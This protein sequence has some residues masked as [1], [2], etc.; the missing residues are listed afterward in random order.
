MLHLQAVHVFACVCSSCSP[1][2]G[3]P[4]TAGQAE[5]QE[6]QMHT[7]A[8]LLALLLVP[9][10]LLKGRQVDVG[11]LLSCAHHLKVRKWPSLCACVPDSMA[12]KAGGDQTSMAAVSP[13]TR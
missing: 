4:Q 7:M 1:A 9:G 13:R 11:C 5:M 10:G 6:L 3:S 8:W 12:S 2:A